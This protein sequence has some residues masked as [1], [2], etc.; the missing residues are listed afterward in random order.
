MR[1]NADL[2]QQRGFIEIGRYGRVI[3][4]EWENGTIQSAYYDDELGSGLTI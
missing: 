2:C 1:S 4:A 3:M